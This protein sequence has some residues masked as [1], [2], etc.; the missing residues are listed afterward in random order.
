M[1][2]E[3]VRG[4]VGDLGEPCCTWLGFWLL[5]KGQCETIGIFQEEELGV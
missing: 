1:R 2:A 5:I 3:V 4:E